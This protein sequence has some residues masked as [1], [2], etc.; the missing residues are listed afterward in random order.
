MDREDF[1][2]KDLFEKQRKHL[3]IFFDKF[4]LLEFERL[5]NL[6][7]KCKGT[8]VFTGVG[9]S[10]IIAQKI[11]Q[12]LLSTGTKSVF[13]SALE[14]LHGS[15]AMV[16]EED[17]FFC[18]SKSGQTNELLNLIP[19]IQIRKAKIVSL[20]CDENSALAKQADL[21]IYLPIEKELCPFNLAPTISTTAQLLFGDALTVALMR[22]KQISLDQYAFNHP[23]GSIGKKASV[24][25][26]DLM[27]KKDN[28]PIGFSENTVIEIISEL[29]SKQCGCVI[30]VNQEKKALGIFTDGDLRRGLEKQ[31]E[32]ILHRKLEE[33]MTSKFL[34]IEQDKLAWHALQKMEK[35]PKKLV[36]VLP[37][38]EKDRLVG[39]IRMHDILQT[40][41]R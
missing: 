20:T 1:M 4:D 5:V 34:F 8:L 10:A 11:S 28:I 19:Y 2:F 26:R 35:D 6:C 23:A 36:S 15:I 30:I 24:C 22:V 21:S 32:S 9:K 40:G 41:I 3:N 39:I 17:L 25:V 33:L 14:A 38:I 16:S 13:L 29:S 27:I 7:A 37:V 31:G 12:T 18:L